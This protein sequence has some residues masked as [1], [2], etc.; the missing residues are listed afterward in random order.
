MQEIFP[1]RTILDA[2]ENVYVSLEASQQPAATLNAC[3]AF[4]H[5][6]SATTGQVV[7]ASETGARTAAYTTG[8][9][10]A[11]VIS[12]L[13]GRYV[14]SDGTVP[15]TIV[16]EA[17]A[18]LESVTLSLDGALVETI[19]FAQGETVTSIQRTI[20]VAVSGEQVHTLV[21]QAQDRSGALQQTLYPV[22]FTLDTQPPVATINTDSL[23]LAQTW[24]AGSDVLRFR[25]KASDTVELAAVQIKIGDAPFVDVTFDGVDWFTALQVPDPEGKTLENV[26]VRA[27]DR[28]G[29]ITEVTETIG[30]DLTGGNVPETAITSQPP[31]PDSTTVEFSFTGTDNAGNPLS[32]FD[33]RLDGG[34][35]ASC[36]SPKQYADLSNGIHRF[37]VRAIDDDGYVD[38]TPAFVEWTVTAAGPSATIDLAQV[39]TNPTF[40]RDARFVFSGSADVANFECSLDGAAYAPCS[41]EESYS[42]LLDGQH[43]FQV[44]GLDAAG[45][46]GAPSR[47]VWRVQNAPPVAENRSIG[48]F[49]DTPIEITLTALDSDPVTFE[50][51]GNPANGAVQFIAANIVR[52]TP[53]SGRSGPDAFS[54]RASDGQEFS[55][56]GTV[57]I[58]VDATTVAVALS[59]VYAERADDGMVYFMWETATETGNAGFNLYMAVDEGDPN[60][61]TQNLIPSSVIDSAA[62]VRYTYAAQV[63]GD[64][65]FIEMVNVDGSS[66]RYGPYELGIGY[67]KPSVV[68]PTAV[69]NP[70]YLPIISGP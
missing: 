41:G 2:L 46:A 4:G 18:G 50:I 11:A 16:A 58:L 26:R 49:L 65:Y 61:I 9:P 14:A 12:P 64:V 66:E 39:P 36:D 43:T 59:Y 37:E 10:L 70:V 15:V 62:P 55:E 24:G 20:P 57:D 68:D 52:Y 23:G 29:R 32:A 3:D 38:P 33:C 34:D 31:A 19:T 45:N 56:P 63:A 25:G 13:Q 17:G 22:S 67:G 35:F 53:D 28:A 5:C 27:I 60:L 48:T 7:A 51:V 40:S 8:A 69:V 42:G 44:R 21:A 47:Y 30:V 1:D 54:F 6:N